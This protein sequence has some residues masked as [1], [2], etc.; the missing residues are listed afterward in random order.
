[1]LGSSVSFSFVVMICVYLS[2][3]DKQLASNIPLSNQII[4]IV[5]STVHA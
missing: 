3:C 2:A 1:M 5:F 4:S